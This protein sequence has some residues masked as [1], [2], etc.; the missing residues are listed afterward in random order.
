MHCPL[1]SVTG[2]WSCRSWEKNWRIQRKEKKPDTFINEFKDLEK[3][4]NA[5]YGVDF[6]EL[7]VRPVQFPARCM[8]LAAYFR[9][10]F[11]RIRICSR[12]SPYEAAFEKVARLLQFL[13]DEGI[14]S[15][16]LKGHNQGSMPYYMY[17]MSFIVFYCMYWACW[18]YHLCWTDE[19][20][21]IYC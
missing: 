21:H 13:M 14:K 8:H 7:H 15:W 6:H 1:L 16:G 12:W 17:F 2:S 3:L 19:S 11:H 9:R 5:V 4:E 20:Y 10:Y 18:D